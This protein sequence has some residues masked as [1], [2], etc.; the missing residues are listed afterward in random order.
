VAGLRVARRARD[1]FAMLAAFTATA[2]VALPAAVN[3][4]VVMGLLPTTGFTLPFLSYGSN[5]LVVCGLA[6]G[7][8]LRIAAVEAPRQPP[9]IRAEGLR[10]WGRRR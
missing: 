2:L 9:A 3:A 10:R 4:G 6:V 7:L 5:S 1:P 8:L